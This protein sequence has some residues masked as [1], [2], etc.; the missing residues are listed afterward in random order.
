MNLTP[1]SLILAARG[2]LLAAMLSFTSDISLAQSSTWIAPGGSLSPGVDW[3]SSGNWSNG[4]VPNSSTATAV[5]LASTS[6]SPNAPAR[7]MPGDTI[8]L[9]RIQHQLPNVSA[10]PLPLTL[11]NIIVD[12][13]LQVVGAGVVDQRLG[14]ARGG[15]TLSTALL[16]NGL[17]EFRNAAAYSASAS[18]QLGIRGDPV[19]AGT[20]RFLDSSSMT[21]RNVFMYGGSVVEF[22]GTS[23]LGNDVVFFMGNGVPGNTVGNGSPSLIFRDQ[24]VAG[25]SVALLFDPASSVIVRDQANVSLLDIHNLSPFPIQT[26]TV[27]ISGAEGDVRL[28]RLHGNIG[29][30]LGART[31]RFEQLDPSVPMQLLGAIGGTGGLAFL[32]PGTVT[33]GNPANSF[34]G[35][36]QIQHGAKVALNG[37]RLSDVELDLAGNLT[38]TGTIAGNL[39]NLRGSAVRPDGT[40]NILGNFTQTP[41]PAGSTQTALGIDLNGPNRLVIGG[42]AQLGGRLELLASTSSLLNGPTTVSFL[43]AGSV[44][45]QFGE[46]TLNG[47]SFSISAM[48]TGRIV[49]APTSVSFAVEQRPFA[50]IGG[51]SSRQAFGAYLD[52]TLPTTTG[53]TGA[54]RTNLNSL[55][56]TASVDEAL[57]QLSPDRYSVLPEAAF[58]AALQDRSALDQ[59]FALW[60][61]RSARKGGELFFDAGYGRDGF[62]ATAGLPESR[63]RHDVGRVGGAW[64]NDRWLAGAQLGYD[65]TDA[66][67]DSAGSTAKLKSVRPAVFLQYGDEAFFLNASANF[68]RDDYTLARLISFPGF[69][70]TATASP[71]GD[72]TGLS[73]A[74]GYSWG[75]GDWQLSPSAAFLHSTWKLDA[76]SENGAPGA[77]VRIGD[78]TNH[79]NR[80]RV[81]FDLMRRPANGRLS[82]G[83]AAFWWH[84]FSEDRSFTAGFAGASTRYLA[85]GRPALRDLLEG[86]LLVEARLGAGAI[87]FLSVEGLWAQSIK[88]LPHFSAGIGWTF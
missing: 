76:F 2:I 58:V 65:R 74:G 53:A 24:A 1:S 18:M 26:G 7:I 57:A 64:Q 17:L 11:T 72:R 29:V 34:T 42:I 49:Y 61:S 4:V 83:I 46:V 81:G 13:T 55:P 82:F 40:L 56:T 50:S 15:V 80:G 21:M 75:S 25:S 71:H 70:Q 3:N 39:S 12:G 62:A 69:A 60:R 68:S 52:A 44:S 27:D 35:L 51:A 23:N 88:T 73:L 9:D 14:E 77:N 59:R 79:S 37:G 41:N 48:L 86:K 5:F 78:W 19:T 30:N 28:R 36:T 66:Q 10:A 33:I 31:L 47:G 20:V 85:P 63:F 38:G 6:G 8:T 87:A 67:L 22:A 84:E 43:N 54:L 32:S 16:V 45:G